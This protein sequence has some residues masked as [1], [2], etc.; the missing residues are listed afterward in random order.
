MFTFIRKH[1]YLATIFIMLVVASFVIFFTDRSHTGFGGDQGDYGSI[2]GKPITGRQYLDAKKEALLKHFFQFQDWPRAGSWSEQLGW[3]T[4]KQTLERLFMVSRLKELNIEVGDEAVARQIAQYFRDVKGM[5]VPEAYKA[6]V[7]RNLKPQGLTDED[8]RRHIKHELGIMQLGQAVSAGA[9]LVTQATAEAAYKQENE[10]VDTKVAIF[11]SSNYLA[12]AKLNIDPKELTQY[13]S[14][15]VQNY[16]LPERAQ[17]AYVAFDPINY[18]AEAGKEMLKR[19][20]LAQA[21][22]Q[23]YVKD[24]ANAY[25][26]EKGQPLPAEKAKDKIRDDIRRRFSQQVARQKAYEFASE[27]LEIQP[28]A[29]KNLKT[30]ADKK[31]LK[32]METEPFTFVDGPKGISGARDL[33]ARAFRLTPQAPFAE[34]PVLV[35]GVFYVLG[36]VNRLPMQPQ[37]YAAVKD[38]VEQDYIK[39]RSRTLAL[40]AGKAFADAVKTGL[41]AGKKFEDVAKEKKVALIDV[42]PFSRAERKIEAI[43]NL[44]LSTSQYSSAATAHKAGEAS[45]LVPSGDGGFVL[46]VEKYVPADEEKMKKEIKDYLDNLRS[47]QANI[48]FSD[49]VSSGFEAA[50]VTA[51]AGTSRKK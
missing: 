3:D 21:I 45:D 13:Y 46:Y 24:G 27:L 25:L 2:Q 40:E 9:R 22:D 41:T 30:L 35:E 29:A 51:P 31:S 39:N 1:Q 19:T 36:Y 7:E 11:N 18:L 34:E 48:A 43:E 38:K 17:V 12:Q 50:N 32:L 5:T 23:Q 8:F 28:L 26:D 15:L 10:Q 47:R 49:W 33:S 6:F 44:S 4:E 20:E 37:P 16:N 42:A 14:N